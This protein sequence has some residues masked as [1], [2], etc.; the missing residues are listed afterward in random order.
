MRKWMF[1]GPAALA[2]AVLVFASM[3]HA[4]DGAA[5]PTGTASIT[6]KVT[7]AD[8]APAANVDVMVALA[9]EK[10]EKKT[11]GDG[12]ADAPKKD[13]KHGNITKTDADG[14][15]KFEGLA[16]GSYQVVAKDKSAG[17]V[18]KESITLSDGQSAEVA[19]KLEAK[20]RAAGDGE[21]KK[22]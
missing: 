7:G 21:K 17:L 16:A 18:G 4:E 8:G 9:G 1:A 12:A 20:S 11:G 15:A 10:K 19:I 3:G 13:K 2:A 22:S 5:K 6:A 14:I